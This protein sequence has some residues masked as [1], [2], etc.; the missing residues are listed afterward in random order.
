MRIGIYD[1]YLD[2]LGGGE[3]YM[4]TIASCLSNDHTVHVFW[5]HKKDLDAV[6]ERFDLNVTK[7][8]LVKNIFTPQFST[9]DRLKTTHNY[10]AL[11]LLTDGSIPLTLSKKLFLHV[12]QPL[13][14]GSDTFI[15]TFKKMRINKVFYNSYFTLSK[16]K[17]LFS[18]SKSIVIYPPVIQVEKIES[19]KNVILHVGR[20]RQMGE[21]GNDFKKHAVMTKAFMEMVDNGLTEWKFVLAAGLKDSD[22]KAFSELK[23]STEGYPIE[24]VENANSKDLQKLYAQSR[25]YW[26]ASGYGEDLDKNPELAE[27]FGISTVEAMSAGVVPIVINAGGQKEIVTNG[28]DGFLWDNLVE[29]KKMT[30]NVM[31]NEDLWTKMS[32]KAHIS[33][34]KYSPE[35]FCRQIN[36]LIK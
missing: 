36:N 5:D 17:N 30:T 16:S 4:M 6:A 7:V 31:E 8:R 28:E 26:H 22:I 33:A 35:T 3:K 25:I 2:D 19:K 14:L 10:D 32:S 1:P 24:F 18:D 29:L 11:I 27:H 20:Y 9:L 21:T 23:K 13:T 34:R 15:S 12:Q